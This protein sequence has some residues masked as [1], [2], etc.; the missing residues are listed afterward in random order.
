[1]D[2]SKANN[3]FSFL[4]PKDPPIIG[5]DVSSSSVK[6]VCVS[7]KG[8]QYTLEGFAIEPVPMGAITEGNIVNLEAVAG[9]LVKCHSA[10]DVS[11]KTVAIALPN[12][13]V[14]QKK[15]S[16][17]KN[18]TEEEIYDA[19]ETEA[20]QYIPFP[21]D[22]VNIDWQIV[23]ESKNNQEENEILITVA[24]KENIEDRVACLE[25]AGLKAQI[26]TTEMFSLMGAVE[27]ISNFLEHKEVP[28]VLIEGGH[29]F[30]N[31]NIFQNGVNVFTKDLSIGAFYITEQI[32]NIY[33]IS[34]EEAENVKRDNGAS[35]DNYYEHVLNPFITSF[36]N[37]VN[38]A[39]QFYCAQSS[40]NV[41]Y[42]VLSGGVAALPNIDISIANTVGVET[43]KANPFINM[44]MSNKIKN[45]LSDSKIPLLLNAFGLALRRFD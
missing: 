41:G 4:E 8:S 25:A 16:V 44:N 24:K 45:K 12:N 36:T 10:L 39:I 28:I 19:V 33:N 15:I 1:M 21:I 34:L 6:M 37:E 31:V 13:M 11:I 43:F 42:V 26:I 20:N 3:Y 38:R 35:I 18:L 40:L 30:T 17:D 27:F 32:S 2:L 22:E 5:V 29:H 14:I 9:A 7:K 23:G